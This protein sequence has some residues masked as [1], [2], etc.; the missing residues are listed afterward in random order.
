MNLLLAFFLLQTLPTGAV[1]GTVRA[2][3]GKPA[4]G[5]RVYA[6]ALRDVADATDPTALESLSETDA[7][8]RYRL[9]IPP[10]RYYIASGAVAAPTYYP[11]TANR[12]AAIPV[13]IASGARLDG[14]DFSRYVA[15]GPAV[16]EFTRTIISF[17][18]TFG[19]QAPV[20]VLPTMSGV[21]R[22]PNGK[23]AAGMDVL[24]VPVPGGATPAGSP[25]S[26]AASTAVRGRADDTG[27]FRL[28]NVAPGSY[29]I[30]AG[31]PDFIT[32]YPGTTEVSK[33]TSIPV[34]TRD[35][36]NVDFTVSGGVVLSGRVLAVGG[37]PAM[38]ASVQA[39]RSTG[40]S[41]SAD[42]AAVLADRYLWE[43]RVAALDGSFS[44]PGL[45]AGR[46]VVEVSAEFPPNQTREVVVGKEAISGIDFALP[47]VLLSGGI[48]LQDGSA[49]PD[50]NRLGS[51][52]FSS[53][54]GDDESTILRVSSTGT[55]GGILDPG[56]YRVDLPSLPWDYS[57][58]SITSAGRDLLKESFK[59][60]E[61][62]PAKIEIRLERL[63]G[64]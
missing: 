1:T 9:D 61:T 10:G 7:S 4:P 47:I 15:R 63:S 33:A 14:I 51:I 6:I 16:S 50:A 12:A 27:Q 52:V 53:T 57:I 18:A 43:T 19:L 2:A 48:V 45:P 20:P 40:P 23:P 35:V 11:D 58:V 60:T 22:L 54:G 8:G 13:T 49:V 29:Y 62:S 42:V 28:V 21:I 32:L 39:R 25:G 46:Y 55:F 64:K 56:E 26:I 3:D 59:M 36:I 30:V 5:V 41:S 31:T 37:A 38:G 34:N 24:A 17:N 44:I